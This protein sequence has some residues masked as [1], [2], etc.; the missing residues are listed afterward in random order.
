M[1]SADHRHPVIAPLLRQIIDFN[2]Y[3][4]GALG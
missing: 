4:A 2:N 1:K 3:V